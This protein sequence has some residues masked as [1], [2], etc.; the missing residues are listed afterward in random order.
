LGSALP[1]LP[2]GAR[3]TGILPARPELTPTAAPIAT[4]SKTGP[5]MD[6]RRVLADAGFDK[7]LDWSAHLKS[8]VRFGTK[9]LTDDYFKGDQFDRLEIKR[10]TG[11]HL[12]AVERKRFRVDKLRFRVANRE[13]VETR[14]LVAELDLPMRV[15][16]DKEF[17]KDLPS[18]TGVLSCMHPSEVELNQY[19]FLTVLSVTSCT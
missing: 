19:A 7:R 12:S 15:R 18:F 9:T 11:E 8:Y 13:D 2:G 10:N 14:G 5:L 4:D 17:Y 16:G 1:P 3:P 6:F